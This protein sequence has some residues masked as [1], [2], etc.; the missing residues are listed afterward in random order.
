MLPRP[1]L[2]ALGIKYRRIPIL[3]IG[4]DVYCD[5]RLILAELE[6]RFASSSY[7]PISSTQSDGIANLLDSFTGDGGVFGR[8]AQI[9]PADLPAMNDPT[10][11]KDREDFM[12]RSWKKADTDRQRPEAMAHMR[13]VFD[14]YESML[15]DGRD[16]IAGTEQA[17]IADV[18]SV[19]V[20]DWMFELK[21][22]PEQYFSDKIYPKTYAWVQ[23]WRSVLKAAKGKALKPVTIKGAD[24]IKHICGASV[25]SDLTVDE[26]DPFGLEEGTNVQVWPIESGFNHKDQGRLIGLTKDEVVI[27]VPTK[28]GEQEV[29]LHMPRWGF[30]I[31]KAK[32]GAGVKL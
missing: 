24:A 31:V 13:K 2:Q 11:L 3:S 5:T 6:K 21:S 28:V 23:R 25:T 14:V 15:A 9:L 17:S 16:W 30:R 18:K 22:L 32:G 1:D 4:R 26:T 7:T 12:G 27:A 20:I 8:A 19:W 29:Y 10:F